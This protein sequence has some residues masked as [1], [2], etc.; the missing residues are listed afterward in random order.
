MPSAPP[1]DP[2]GDVAVL[3]M[4]GGTATWKLPSNMVLISSQVLGSAAGT[5]TF[6]SI[7]A[8]FKHLKVFIDATATGTGNGFA[9]LNFNGDVTPGDYFVNYQTMAFSGTITGNGNFSNPGAYVGTINQASGGAGGLEATIY[10]YA[11]A[12]LKGYTAQGMGYAYFLGGGLWDVTSAI[13]SIAVTISSGATFTAGS[14]FS[15][16]GVN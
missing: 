1:T 3:P 11:G 14:T 5:V 15:L 8:S 6:S 9:Q 7:P 16:Y 13:T 12:H 2:T 4:G 10:G